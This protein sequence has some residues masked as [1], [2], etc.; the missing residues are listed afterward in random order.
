[1]TYSLMMEESARCLV[2]D[3]DACSSIRAGVAWLRGPR[4]RRSHEADG[5]CHAQVGRGR[6][7]EGERLEGGGVGGGEGGRGGG[8]EGG[9]WGGGEGGGGGG[10]EGGWC[11]QC[12]EWCFRETVVE[13]SF[14]KSNHNSGSI[15]P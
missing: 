12:D 5:A 4:L 10:R 9:G 8:W 2:V 3:C 1:M 6:G 13:H 7:W 14:V 15:C 11:S